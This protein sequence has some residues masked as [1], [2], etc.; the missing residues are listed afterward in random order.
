M[1]YIACHTIRRP[2]KLGGLFYVSDNS[3]V[4]WAGRCF[5]PRIANR[6]LHTFG[7]ASPP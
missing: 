5:A 6:R 4:G 7:P 2:L 1:G 3:A